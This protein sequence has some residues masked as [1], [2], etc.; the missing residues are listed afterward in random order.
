MKI[1]TALAA[2]LFLTACEER[3]PLRSDSEYAN[4]QKNHFPGSD[5]GQTPGGGSSRNS[6]D[7]VTSPP[8][9][10]Q[11]IQRLPGTPETAVSDGGKEAGAGSTGSSY[12]SSS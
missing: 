7:T 6:S 4:P 3:I 2:L 5:P 1:V 9:T 11:G 12:K 8:S 10:D